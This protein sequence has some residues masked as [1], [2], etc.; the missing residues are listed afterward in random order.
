MFTFCEL[1]WNLFSLLGYPNGKWIF[2]CQPISFLHTLVFLE[3]AYFPV[4]AIIIYYCFIFLI[5]SLRSVLHCPWN[6]YFGKC[7]FVTY[8]FVFQ[9]YM[10]IMSRMKIFHVTVGHHVSANNYIQ[11]KSKFVHILSILKPYSTLVLW[12]N[13]LQHTNSCSHFISNEIFT[14]SKWK[15]KIFRGP[16]IK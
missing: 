13:T 12:Y 3:F 1:A 6:R 2:S 15:R 7:T 11:T 8:F 5:F 14:T 4:T 10:K 9:L 16:L